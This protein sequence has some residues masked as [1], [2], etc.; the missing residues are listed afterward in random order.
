VTLLP[1]LTD[2]QFMAPHSSL[3]IYHQMVRQRVSVHWH[4]F[5]EMF[6]VVA[7]AGTHTLNGVAFP[8]APGSL[9][10]LTPADFHEILPDEDSELD[11]LNVIF[12][13]DALQEEMRHL[14][15][16]EIRDFFTRCEGTDFIHME[17][18]FRRLCLES[19]ERRLG[20][21]RV[22]QG[23]LER[24]L[25]EL[26]RRCSPMESVGQPTHLTDPQRKIHQALVYL[27]HHF[28]ESL[29][30]EQLS[31]EACL[32]PHYFSSC[33]HLATGAPFQVYR[34]DLRLRFARSLLQ[35]ADLPVTEI[36]HASGFV[37]LSHFERVFKQ[38]YGHSPRT[39]RRSWRDTC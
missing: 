2:E 15:S 37:N 29:T 39:Y 4:E 9:F 20:H 17:A 32:S 25:I 1:R 16:A 22:M 28:R 31:K 35:V 24:A 7:G 36:C 38:K 12:T 3:Q 23:V 10:L 14:L 11:L 21:H 18:E 5:Y 30:L 33:F 8:L 6:F 34:R 26:I 19:R 27:H 13:E